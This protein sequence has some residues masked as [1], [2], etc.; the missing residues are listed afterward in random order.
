MVIQ[1][2]ERARQ[3]VGQKQPEVISLQHIAAINNNVNLEV[4]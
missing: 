4:L 1:R 3:G 2:V